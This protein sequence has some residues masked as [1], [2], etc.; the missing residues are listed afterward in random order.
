MTNALLPSIRLTSPLG[1]QGGVI[2]YRKSEGILTLFQEWQRLFLLQLEA[3]AQ[4]PMPHIDYM[5]GIR[6]E[7]ARRKMLTNDQFAFAQ[8]LSPDRNALDLKLK[9]LDES[10]NFCGTFAGRSLGRP[11]HVDHGPHLKA[12]A[13]S[14]TVHTSK[15]RSLNQLTGHLI[16]SVARAYAQLEHGSRDRCLTILE[17]TIRSIPN[18]S[19]VQ[20]P[21]AR[22]LR[23]LR[24]LSEAQ[25]HA[26]RA[27]LADPDCYAGFVELATS[28]FN[29][30]DVQG[31][32]ACVDRCRSRFPEKLIQFALA[33]II[34]LI[35]IVYLLQDLFDM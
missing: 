12:D 19:L 22:E 33:L 10:W 18:Q 4:D 34:D 23:E 7:T 1:Q 3:H 2:L 32:A 28:L 11:I 14:R 17:N 20:V 26:E 16:T 30:G 5:A 27:I 9:I 6:D 24:R 15:P 8:L 25:Q 21:L 31:A 35:L 29:R 13:F